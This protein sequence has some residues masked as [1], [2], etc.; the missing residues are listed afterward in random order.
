MNNQTL[1]QTP[2]T[3]EALMASI[4]ENER[5]LTEQLAETRQ[6]F[7][8]QIAER[9][10]ERMEKERE[11]ERE[12]KELDKRFKETEKL[13]KELSKSVGGMGNSNGEMAEEY[14]YNAFKADTSFVN[15]KFDIIKKNSRISNR[16]L[17]AEYDLLLFNGKSAAIIEVKYNAKPENIKVER[18]IS[19]V[20]TFKKLMPAYKDF[21]IYLGV[22]AMSFK[23]GLEAELHQA[24]IATIRPVGKKVVKFDKDV[25]VF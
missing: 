8:E 5:F 3:Y 18:I 17:E 20:E 10:R 12:R 14:F 9:E 25:R 22:A 23:E 2:L 11:R 15:E 16:E 24:G 19:R 4:Y 6:I 21:N 1:Q 7:R 13:I